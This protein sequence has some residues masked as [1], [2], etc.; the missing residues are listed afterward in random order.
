MKVISDA[1]HG[2][3]TITHGNKH[4]TMD[5]AEYD[6]RVA[7]Q[8]AWYNRQKSDKGYDKYHGKAAEMYDPDSPYPKQFNKP[9]FTERGKS[10][11]GAKSGVVVTAN[12]GLEE[13]LR[14][15]G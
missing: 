5:R 14:R 10:T 7:E 9:R 3:V 6:K 4:I 15:V 12:N 11:S 1:K 13:H 8:T 2:K